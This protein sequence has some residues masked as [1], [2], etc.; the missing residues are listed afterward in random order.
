[1]KKGAIFDLDGTLVDSMTVW[2]NADYV[3][4]ERYGFTPD[5]EYWEKVTS[6]P[7]F[8]GAKYITERFNLNKTPEEIADELYRTVLYDYEHNI[9]LKDGAKELLER[10]YKDGIK[11][12]VATS[13]VE[14]MVFAVL[15]S[16]GVFEYFS[17]FSYCD[18]V[19]K[20]K[21]YPDVYADAAK[22]MGL[23]AEECYIFED[24]PYALEG[25]KKAGAEVI[26]VYD[27]Y[28]AAEEKRMRERA[29][30]FI[31]SLKDFKY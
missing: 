24:V 9:K 30:R 21:A 13:N 10:L 3:L 29:D 1:M 22:K 12:A 28:S 27:E 31:L 18:T 23:S 11:M 15:K 5:D 6:V 4:S 17:A 19:G 7:F 2:E 26:G 20:N 16:N 25:A 14:K 8:E